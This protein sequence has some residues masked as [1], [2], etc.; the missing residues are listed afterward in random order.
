MQNKKPKII[1]FTGPESTAKSTLSK[2]VSQL[3]NAHLETEFAR[4]YVANLN[5]PYNYDDVVRIAKSQI[6]TYR[7]ACGMNKHLVVFD[8]F[9]IITKVWFKEVYGKMP[10]WFEDFL[11]EV[12]ID[13]HLLCYPDIEW[14]ADGVRE[15]KEKRLYLF[16]QYEFELKRYNFNY[17]IINGHGPDR[18]QQAI[19]HI[20]QILK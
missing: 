2:E 5:R 11:A 10:G 20:N 9:L 13:L 3:L 19:N 15:N 14:V 18:Y 6:G 17:H 8:T 16:E 12:K 1:V 4:D 7:N